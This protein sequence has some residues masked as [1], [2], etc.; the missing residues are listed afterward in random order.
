MGPGVA[1]T[2]KSMSAPPLQCALLSRITW[3]TTLARSALKAAMKMPC[4]KS[5]PVGSQEPFTP[6]AGASRLDP[7][8]ERLEW[9]RVLFAEQPRRW[10]LMKLPVGRCSRTLHLRIH[11]NHGFESTA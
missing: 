8:L 5:P 2:S 7:R 1:Q 6:E 10:E 11:R 9:Q 3:D 4:E